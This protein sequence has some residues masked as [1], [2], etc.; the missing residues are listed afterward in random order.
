MLFDIFHFSSV[1]TNKLEFSFSQKQARHCNKA[2]KRTIR[3]DFVV[4]QGLTNQ[5]RTD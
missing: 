1:Y 3:F 5:C 2:L 4:S